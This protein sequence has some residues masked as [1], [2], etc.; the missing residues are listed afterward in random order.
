MRT[1]YNGE[2]VYWS[3]EPGA[4]VENAPASDLTGPAR[5]I[6]ERV[7]PAGH[8]PGRVRPSAPPAVSR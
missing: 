4:P 8:S 6:T 3:P 2:A 7:H 1:G 5:R